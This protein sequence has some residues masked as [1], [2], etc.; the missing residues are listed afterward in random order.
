MRQAF[1]ALSVVLILFLVSCGGSGTSGGGDG[2][3]GGNGGGGGGGST[4]YKL[5]AWSELGM[6]CIDGKDYSV[7]SVLPPYNVIHAQLVR[8]GNPPA[9]VTSGVTITY[10]AVADGAGSINT[11]SSSKTNFWTW[12]QA[13]FHANP[14]PDVGLAGA[15]VQ[16]ATPRAM[17]F[18]AAQGYWE[19]VGIPTVPYDDSGSV[20]PYPTAKIVARDA[21]GNV[22]ASATLVLAV[23]DEMSCKNCHAS[24]S[25]S[26]AMPNGGWENNS[27][28][29]KDPK[30]NI[31]RKHDDR[32]DIQPYLSALAANGYHYQNTL[33][34]TATTGTPVLCAACHATNALGAA[35][36]TGV[37]ALTADM[38]TLH[39]PVVNP[40]TGLS[41]DNAT[42][43]QGSCYLC[44]P[45]E[46]TQCQRGA[47][48]TVACFDCHGNLTHV[49]DPARRGWLDLP[50]CQMCHN[51]GTRYTTTFSAPGVWRSTSDTR[52][53]TNNNVPV[54]NA[55][56]YR[57]SAG[58]GSVYCAACHGSP[59]AEYPSQKA[60]DNIQ[61]AALQ[62]YAA[63]ITE[64]ALCHT[65]TIT[66]AAAGPHGMHPVDQN[67]VNTHDSAVSS[68]GSAPCAYCHGA[69][70]RGTA[71]SVNKPARTFT[72][73]GGS[74]TLLAGTRVGCYDCHNGPGG[75]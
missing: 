19:T 62:G 58:H 27:D 34:T 75:G 23:S 39:G 15:Y 56:L 1:L 38:H 22:L 52:F 31:L 65:S 14:A 60:N 20:N 37:G 71:L 10:E 32:F 24:G 29:L 53:A 35:G 28:P 64:C 41:L 59:H 55:T 16:S 66:A 36:V 67:W 50:A 74:K 54:Q 47:M 44:H 4:T 25:N 33:Y 8:P 13:L 72:V 6:H 73:E 46:T 40:S 45:G 49:G 57:Y 18:N 69:D 30:L 43:P 21:S 51:S 12:V 68:G 63:R 2:G 61:P 3:G 11:G 48:H 70:Y 26:A 42:T 5:L 17:T 7:F 9:L